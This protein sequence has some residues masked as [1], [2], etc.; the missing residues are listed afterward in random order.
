MILK[1]HLLAS[2]FVV[3]YALFAYLLT[4]I[5]L[6]LVGCNIVSFFNN[7]CFHRFGKRYIGGICSG[8][9]ST[10]ADVRSQRFLAI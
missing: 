1:C 7:F 4:L 5:D 9:I 6:S 3:N 10:G 8:A 2:Y